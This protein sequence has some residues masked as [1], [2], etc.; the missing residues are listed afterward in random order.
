M[1]YLRLMIFR[2]F[3]LIRHFSSL[4]SRSFRYRLGL[5]QVTTGVNHSI[6]RK[7]NFNNTWLHEWRE[8]LFRITDDEIVLSPFDGSYDFELLNNSMFHILSHLRSSA[9]LPP[10]REEYT[11]LYKE[12]IENVAVSCGILPENILCFE[13][14]VYK[15][16]QLYAERREYIQSS[17]VHDI[18]LNNEAT[19]QFRA[20]KDH[21]I[22]GKIVGDALGLHPTLG[23]LL[24]PTGGIVGVRNSNC[25]LRSLNLLPSIRKNAIVHD[26][27]GYLRRYHGIGPG[28]RTWI[29]V[30]SR[31]G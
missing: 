24:N 11:Y 15:F 13:S 6:F 30:I 21:L 2:T 12:Q 31:G 20:S 5:E 23:A 25:F 16:F 18:E 1:N 7:N 27:A 14:N 10:S 4:K 28:Y 9:N 29:L 26:A 22:F 19:N 8:Y 3:K 17:G